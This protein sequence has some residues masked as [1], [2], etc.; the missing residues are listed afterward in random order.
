MQHEYLKNLQLSIENFQLNSSYSHELNSQIGGKWLP[1]FLMATAL[2]LWIVFN[3]LAIESYQFSPYPLLFMNLVMY[4]ILAAMASPSYSEESKP[5]S[6][7]MTKRN[8]ID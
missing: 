5:S 4:F 1:Y 2:I 3:I 7:K 8:L 6:T